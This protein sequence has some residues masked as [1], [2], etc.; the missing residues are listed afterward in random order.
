M[1]DIVGM[2][3][4]LSEKLG[5]S[6]SEARYQLDSGSTFLLKNGSLDFF[7]SKLLEGVSVRVVVDGSLGFASTNDMRRGSVR[8]AAE[9]AVSFARKTAKLAKPPVLL[10]EEEFEEGRVEVRPRIKFENVEFDAAV[11]LFKE[12]DAAALEKAGRRGVKIASRLLRADIGVCEKFVVN[13]DGACVRSSIPRAMFSYT[14]IGTHPQRGSAMRQ[15]AL[16]ESRG[17]E[18]L[19]RW[20]VAKL[21]GEEGEAMG[22]VLGQGVPPPKENLDVLIGSEVVGLVCH[23]SSGHPGE[24][25]R[26]IGR[27]AAQAG[28][29]YLSIDSI[30]T[31]VGS[32][33]VNVVDDP[34]IPGSFGFYLYDDEGVKAGK[35]YLIKEGRIA[36]FLHNRETAASIGTRSNGAS[37]ALHYDLEPIVRMA[38][39]YLEPGRM[40]FEELVEDV[41]KGVYIRNFTEWNIDD[42]RFNQRY[43]GFEAYLVENGEL[44]A[45]VRDPVIE[46]T[47]VGLFKAVDAVGNDLRFFGAT[48]GKGDPMQ[49]IP[50]WIGGPTVRLRNVRLGGA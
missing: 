20:D 18:A 44:G 21:M 25:D 36:G 14:L 35:R 4:E 38:N 37:R 10:S 33:L 49:G 27:E 32:P 17:W 26:I 8:K 23:E 41:E 40:S 15:S 39:T 29:S 24:A 5:A 30:G 42:R 7:D 46:M 47:T 22:K 34:T 11:D 16:G 19:E 28:E 48:C 12:A 50:V 9:S 43:K 31:E 13:S 2:A 45:P 6:Y 1:E 3:V